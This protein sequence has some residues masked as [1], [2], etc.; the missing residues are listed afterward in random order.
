MSLIL[1][2]SP[3]GGVGSTMVAANL[4]MALARRGRLV[5][6]LDLSR[7][8]S[9]ALHMGVRPDFT[10]GAVQAEDGDEVLGGVRLIALGRT[11]AAEEL[12]AR[13]LSRPADDEMVIVADLGA[14]DQESL[15][16]LLPNAA[17]RLCV[18]GSDPA[19]AAMLPALFS[20]DGK[21]LAPQTRF[22]LNAV[23]DRMKLN[24]DMGQFMR[25]ALGAAL[26]GSVRRDEAVNE[27]L[28]MLEPLASF[29]PSSA[30]LAD[31]EAIFDRVGEFLPATA[32][33]DQRGAAA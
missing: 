29:A 30:A 33:A 9:L 1:V 3:K 15:S 32:S 19:S 14:S 20:A 26:L 8:N 12:A 31:L 25:S 2:H 11:P 13:T 4:A 5:T 18:L 27:A 24:A 16:A 6:A 23:D 10:A 7:Q 21:P 22:I 17:I 28:A